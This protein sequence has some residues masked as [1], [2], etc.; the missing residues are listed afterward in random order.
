MVMVYALHSMLS[1]IPVSC[2]S[3]LALGNTM[4]VIKY[5]EPCGERTST[6]GQSFAANEVGLG[7]EGTA[8]ICE[9]FLLWCKSQAQGNGTF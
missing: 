7:K 8:A 2:H 6:G 9:A 4:S 5:L 3:S 1:V